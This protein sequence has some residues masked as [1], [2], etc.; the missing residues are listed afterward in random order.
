M[1]VTPCV[2][3]ASSHAASLLTSLNLQRER[4]QFCDC[5]VRQGQSPGQLYPAH[6]CVL[7]ASSPVLASILSS[8]GALVELQAPCLSDSVLALLLNYIYTGVLPYT[9]SQQQYYN[10]LTAASYLQMDELQEALRAWQQTEVNAADNT[11]V[12]TG[13]ENQ[14]YK[15]INNTYSKTMNTLCK[16][17]PLSHTGSVNSPEREDHQDSVNVDTHDE[18]QMHSANVDSC[19]KDV[20]IDTFRSSSN[21]GANHYSRK[22]ASTLSNVSSCCGMCESTECSVNTGHCKQVMYLTPQD[23]IQNI[24]CTAG[25]DGMSRVDKEVQMDQFH[26]AGTVKPET[27][28][29]RTGLKRTEE[30]VVRTV[31]DRSSLYLLCTAEVQ[32]EETNRAEKTQRLCLTLKSKSEEKQANRK[33]EDKTQMHHSPLLRLSTSHIKDNVSP[34]QCSSSSS[35]SSPQPCCEAVPVIRYSSRADMLQLAG[36][37]TMPPY[38]P[39]SQASVSSSMAPDSR[40]DN[41][42]VEGITTKHKNHYGAQ[43]QDYRNNKGHIGTHSWDYKD[44]SYQCA[45]QDLCYKSNADQSDILKQDY[46]SSNTDH[47]EHMGNGLSHITGNNDCY[48]HCDSHQNKNHTKHFRDDSVPHNKDCSSFTRGLK[49]KTDLS[50]DDLPSKHQRLDCSDCHNVWMANAA[51]EQSQDLGAVV[52]LLVQDSGTGSVSH[53]ED[54]CREGESK[55]EHSYSSRR[56]AE[57]DRQDSHCNRYP[58]KTDWYPNLHRAETSTKDATSSQHEHDSD[59][60]NTAMTD[61]RGS[62][63]VC[64]S[65]P[66]TPESCLYNV[67]GG[68]S[69]FERRTTLELEKTSGTEITEPHLT[70]TVPVENNMSE[71]M[72]S[73]VGQSYRGHLNYHCLPQEDTH[74]SHGDS[75][76]KHFHPSL[77]DHSDQSSDEEEIGIFASPGQSPLRQHFATGTT[78]QVLL[79]D[80]STKPDE[81]LVSYKHRSDQGKKWIA[82]GHEDTF[83]NGWGQ[84]NETTSVAGVNRRKFTARIKRGAESFDEAQSKS[85]FAETNVEERESVGKEQSRP[86]AEAI[87]KSGVVEGE[88]QTTTLTVCSPTSV[89]DSVQASVSSTL[90]VCIP[91]TLSASLPKNISAHL[92]TPVHHPFQCSLCDR[93]FSQRGSLNRHTRSHLGVRP[94]P[95]PRCPMTFSRQ[96]RVTEH[97]RVHQ[98]CVLGSDFQ[99]PPS[100]I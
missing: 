81:L 44:S 25:V 8:T 78:D 43:I 87:H 6:R 60:K 71:P 96:Y 61:K 54:L 76:H 64:L 3:A 7:A 69:A 32:E 5:V 75:E 36:V 84:W 21:N 95:C 35:S 80:I 74:L 18:T 83:G 41:D 13:A 11:N 37:S 23:F 50:C 15:D 66:S 89:P 16:H 68:L 48:A 46:H 20:K 52:S 45:I 53:C 9:R 40:S 82:F 42:I 14:P 33:E 26:S 77:L 49:Y 24:P 4:A 30:E 47:D 86:G 39:V 2:Q 91:S 51:E 90:S 67:T 34:S 28:Q 98:R 27:W 99:K 31:E 57:M 100:S 85:W 97:M 73:V 10:L 88:N 12:S 70:F 38:Y 55:E 17:L 92:S 56:P 58:P 93:S 72:Y 1:E 62:V 22:D 29:E 59:N 79:L 65:V 94:F 19:M 63:D